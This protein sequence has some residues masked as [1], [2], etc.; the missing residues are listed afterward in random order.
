[1]PVVDLVTWL[2][3]ASETHGKGS[4][5][6]GTTPQWLPKDVFARIII[7]SEGHDP[8]D[9]RLLQSESTTLKRQLGRVSPGLSIATHTRA[10]NRQR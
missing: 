2:T 10:N 9:R 1:M 4:P 3:Y 7:K 6:K 8:A 5:K